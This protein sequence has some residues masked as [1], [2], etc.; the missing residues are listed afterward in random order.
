MFSLEAR[1]EFESLEP[2]IDFLPFL[3]QTL[4]LKNNKLFNYLI[5][6]LTSVLLLLF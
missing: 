5:S 3:V 4:W 6:G 1:L 2:L